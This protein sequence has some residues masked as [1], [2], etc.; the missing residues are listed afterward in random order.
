M[1]LEPQTDYQVT[2]KG[3]GVPGPR[4]TPENAFIHKIYKIV[5]RNR[6]HIH[7]QVHVCVSV[8]NISRYTCK[9]VWYTCMNVNAD[10]STYT[11]VH[12]TVHMHARVTLLEY[13]RAEYVHVNMPM[14]TGKRVHN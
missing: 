4:R 10:V 12:V 11:R 7:V 2:Y 14:R 5:Q 3:T 8:F 6:E 13:H 9:Y 1:T